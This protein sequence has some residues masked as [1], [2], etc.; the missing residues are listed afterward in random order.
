L[1]IDDCLEELRELGHGASDYVVAACPFEPASDEPIDQTISSPVWRVEV[2]DRDRQVAM[3]TETSPSTT[4]LNGPAGLTIRAF[5]RQLAPYRGRGYSLY[6]VSAL[7]PFQGGRVSGG[8]DGPYSARAACPIL[9]CGASE[10]MRRVIFLYERL[11][12]PD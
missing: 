10:S 2:D 12:L 11:R 3:H 4:L 6:W 7:V 9:G 8:T 1:L 5:V